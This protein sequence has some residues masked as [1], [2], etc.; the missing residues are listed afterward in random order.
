MDW[1]NKYSPGFM[2]VGNKP[3]TLSNER[4]NICSG[5]T[6]ILWISQIVEGKDLSQPLGQKGHNE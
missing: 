6:Y 4:H 3:H 2:C 5:S 1:F